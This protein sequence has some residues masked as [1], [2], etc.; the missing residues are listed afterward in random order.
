MK[1]KYLFT[2]Q[3]NHHLFA[4]FAADAADADFAAD[5]KKCCT[6]ADSCSLWIRNFYSV[7]C[8]YY[9]VYI[10]VCIL[11]ILYSVYC[12]I[13]CLLCCVY[14]TVYTNTVY[15]ILCIK[16]TNFHHFEV[17]TKKMHP[18]GVNCTPLYCI[19]YSLYTILCILCI[20]Y[21]IYHTVYNILPTMH[22]SIYPIHP[23]SDGRRHGM[24]HQQIAL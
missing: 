9:T 21:C 19:Y 7:Y 18:T 15:T 24:M 17:F 1:K 4:D 8:L 13:L 5:F 16:N 20:L 3:H 14:Y 12:I 22:V 2:S 6:L 10:T 23:H 11:C